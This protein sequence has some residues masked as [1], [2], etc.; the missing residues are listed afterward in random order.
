MVKRKVTPP[1][2]PSRTD[3]YEVDLG[4]HESTKRRAVR[5]IPRCCKSL[6]DMRQ[7]GSIAD[8]LSRYR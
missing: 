4:R 8:G 3:S 6:R 5:F 2:K 7:S 1:V